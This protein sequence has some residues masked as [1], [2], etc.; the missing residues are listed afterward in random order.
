[1]CKY[2]SY[3]GLG[4][5]PC[6]PLASFSIHCLYVVS[7]SSGLDFCCFCRF[8]WLHFFLLSIVR[9]WAP[10]YDGVLPAVWVL[11]SQFLLCYGWVPVCSECKGV[12][13]TLRNVISL[14]IKY[15]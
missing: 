5:I 6:S 9:F 4:E 1:M 2:C 7:L 3:V 13:V 11:V 12:S 14:E 15:T 8:I 10:S